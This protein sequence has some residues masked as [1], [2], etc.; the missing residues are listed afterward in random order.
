MKSKRKKSR[1]GIRNIKRI[2]KSYDKGLKIFSPRGA[3][4]YTLKP[5]GA[6]NYNRLLEQ[7][8]QK[9]RRYEA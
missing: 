4:I 2:K 7:K 6:V 5:G 1:E 8:R 9:Y 3:L